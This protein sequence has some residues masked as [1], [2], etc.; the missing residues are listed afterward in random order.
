MR[1]I[2]FFKTMLAAVL[3]LV[4]S[5]GISAQLL[6]ENFDYA[7]GS[8]LTANGWTA[9]SGAGTQAIDVIVPGLSFTGYAGSGIGGAANLDNNGEDVNR[10]FEAQTAGTVY[11]ALIVK[12][13][14]TNSL[15]YFFHLGQS[16][17]GSTF[18]GR[19]WVNATGN[20]VAI[21]SYG[22]T[23]TPTTPPEYVPITPGTPV[24]LVV[25][26]DFATKVSSLYVLNSFAATEPAT[27][28]QTYTE[29]ATL[30]NVGSVAL[31]QYNAA[32]RVVVD[33]IRV[34]TNW[35]Q[36]VAPPTGNPKAGT[37]FFNVAG[38]IKAPDTYWNTATVTIGSS[39][40]GAAVY[41]TTNGSV[42]TTA[43]TLYSTPVNITSTTTFKAI[44]VKSGLDNSV[45]GE[46]TI[47]IAPPATA[48]LPYAESF[49]NT[50]GDWYAYKKAGDKPWGPSANGAYV[51]GYGGGDV[52]S[53]LISP[54]FSSPL[55]G[56]LFNF[57][58]ASRYMGN[59]LSVKYSTNYTGKGDPAAATWT[60]L[61]S[62]AAPTVQDNNY[63]VKTSG[64]IIIPVSGAI[65]LAL[66]YDT[67]ANYSDWRI[68]NA[69]VAVPSSS[70]TITITEVNVPAMM[71]VVGTSD[72]E[73]IHVS[74]LNLT[75]NV[76]LA[77]SGKNA[78]RFS[79]SP[80]SL[81]QTGG[82]VENTEVTITYTPAAEAA[83]TATLTVSSAGANSVVF[84]LTGKGVI[85]TGTGTTENP[86]TVADVKKL[87]NSFA[88]A[89]KYWVRGYI[90]G[91]P[92]AG[93]SAGNLTTVDLE[94][95]FTGKTAIALAEA[96]AETDLTKMIGVQ[97]PTGTIRDALNLED[98]PENLKKQVKVFGT[99]EAYFT[100]APGVKN[101][102]EYQFVETSLPKVDAKEFKVY[103]TAGQLHV[104]ALEKGEVVVFDV[105]GK[106]IY[107]GFL[108]AGHNAINLP[109]RGVMVVKINNRTAKVVL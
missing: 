92:S 45:V 23:T 19:I 6:V 69:S 82:V 47:T 4:G 10:T 9:H 34:A 42:P 33:G 104:E 72:T 25:K 59:P 54:Q 85:L 80:A 22:S 39:T 68:T 70:P 108:Q 76:S 74:G 87:N 27:A 91:V 94:A 90:V 40:E 43:S 103:T 105:I 26:Y 71:A 96:D 7:S 93:N 62:I 3:L 52:E 53:W 75:A 88:S 50:L 67:E 83:D 97:L 99:L 8:L 66:V 84:E 20:G 15:G 35:A 28:N 14:A 65:H 44:A 109:H 102:S 29:T 13:E 41:Y 89:T 32:Q 38:E 5:V 17:I 18:F 60:E 107:K 73:K 63:T 106:Q 86:F 2:T 61:T 37:P 101:T 78:N 58:Y 1:K 11:A 30:A 49:N 100:A 36:A 48:T 81:A 51:N 21:G 24:L 12:T 95:P 56:L 79:V 55:A 31:R 77:I 98:K 46:K 64:N 16:A 57:S